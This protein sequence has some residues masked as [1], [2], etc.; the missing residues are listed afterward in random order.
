[1]INSFL[2]VS[3]S[4]PC[5]KENASSI[6]WRNLVKVVILGLLMPVQWRYPFLCSFTFPLPIE[7][8]N[9]IEVGAKLMEVA[10]FGGKVVVNGFS[11]YSPSIVCEYL[12]LFVR[13]LVGQS[14][15]GQ[16]TSCS[17]EEMTPL[18]NNLMRKYVLLPLRMAW[19]FL[20]SSTLIAPMDVDQYP[21]EVEIIFG[22]W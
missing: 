12:F 3:F 16:C 13:D 21:I 5:S 15:F 1:M 14:M 20:F 9:P 11:G 22:C 7:V 18:L 10:S 4:C 2:R 6:Q 8:K 17:K 19:V